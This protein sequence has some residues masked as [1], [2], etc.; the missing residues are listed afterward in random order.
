M[1]F[2]I[3][4]FV[5]IGLVLFLLFLILFEP[6][7][8]YAVS[9]PDV[10]IGSDAFLS[11]LAAVADVDVHGCSEIEVLTGGS[12]FYEAELQ[13]IRAAKHSVH[14][15]AFLFTPSAV[16]Q[17]FVE[18][19]TERA[20]AGV[21]V[22]VVLDWV[23]SFPCPNKYFDELRSA[24]G[25]VA[26]YQPLR[27]YTFKRFNNRTHRELLVVDGQIG[28]IGGAGIA[29]HWDVGDNDGKAP[30]R[31]MM[32]RVRGDLVIGLQ[33]TFTENWLESTGEILDVAE[34][35]H[36]TKPGDDSPAA[37]A[38]RGLVVISSPTAGRASRARIVFQV[39]LASACKTIHINSP[40]FLPDKSARA[41]LIKA[42]RDRGVKIKIITPGRNNNHRMTGLASQRIYGELLKEG[43]EIHEYEPGMIHKKSL[44]VDGVWS[45]VGSTN[46]DTRS[47]GLNDEVNL[48]ALDEG[49]ARRLREDFEQEL[50][51]SRQVTYEQWLR[52]PMYQRLLAI[53]GRIMERQE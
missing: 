20:R 50:A 13:A 32:C 10:P 18:A 24:G 15:E 49:L 36:L 8:R 46:F 4:A 17:K 1:T 14:L 52:R 6:S 40:Y 25:Q 30:W 38:V 22:R 16:A 39:L 47:F 48:A 45:V 7:L 19:L 9:R 35:F 31:D 53:V 42:A 33:T 2:S 41:E 23:G 26:W 12:A 27:W 5:C 28:F 44:V 43:I 37:G 51:N 3:I 11:L 34:E 29:A 21:H